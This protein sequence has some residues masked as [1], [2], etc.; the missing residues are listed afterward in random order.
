MTGIGICLEKRI[1]SSWQFSWHFWDIMSYRCFQ[2]Y[3]YPKMDVFFME[4]HIKMDD[5][6]VPLFLETSIYGTNS[7]KKK[8]MRFPPR[9]PN[10]EMWNKISENSSLASFIGETSARRRN[11]RL[12]QPKVAQK[13][14]VCFIF[15]VTP[16]SHWKVVKLQQLKKKKSD[17]RNGSHFRSSP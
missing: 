16:A 14:K 17:N 4:R 1:F 2:K 9:V 3:E 5:L 13:I 11:V 12:F 8:D 7:Q 10:I 15:F 6:G